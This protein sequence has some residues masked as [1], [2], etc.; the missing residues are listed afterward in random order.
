MNFPGVILAGSLLW[1]LHNP[2]SLQCMVDELKSINHPWLD[3]CRILPETFLNGVNHIDSL[4]SLA[5]KNGRYLTT[6]WLRVKGLD[7]RQSWPS[8]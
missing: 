3:R 2:L 5:D 6:I 1:L 8:H 4:A 7:A